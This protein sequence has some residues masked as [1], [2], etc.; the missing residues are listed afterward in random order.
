MGPRRPEVEA[1]DLLSSSNPRIKRLRRLISQRKA[2]SEERAFVV[3]G[4]AVVAEALALPR[5]P[6][7]GGPG[8]DRAAADAVG[9]FTSRVEAVFVDADGSPELVAAAAA[10]G[11]DV[12]PVTS[13][14]LASVLD[15]VNPQPVAAIVGNRQ[16]VVDDLGRGLVL[17]LVDPRDPGNAGTLIRS[18]EAAGAAG[19]V[20]TGGAVDPTNPKVLRASAGA[21]LRF[22]VV[23][24]PDTDAVIDKLAAGGRALVATVIDDA[25][26][27]YD[28]VD[29]NHVVVALGNESH[30]LSASVMARAD[31]QMTIPLVG[32][33][34]SLNLGVAGSV[35]CFEA[36]RQRRAR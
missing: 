4:P 12:Y 6:G 36:L 31:L 17:L 7:G 32:P 21:G 16:W 23:V 1:T 2:R 14:V 29:L 25:A 10:Q 34:E 8:A 18:A 22:P 20:F 33:T 28:E 24:A 30:G 15:T 35:I 3:E 27:S 13:G 26:V 19:I 5:N 9:S 11:V